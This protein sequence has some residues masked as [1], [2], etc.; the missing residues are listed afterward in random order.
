MKRL[1]LLCLLPLA[2]LFPD[3]HTKLELKR[4]HHTLQTDAGPCHYTAITGTIPLFKLGEKKIA[5]MFFVAYIEKDK[6]DKAITFV[7]PG[8]PGGSCA[9]EVISTI[10][11]RRMQTAEEGG[12]ILPPYKMIDNPESLLPWTDLVFVD[13]VGTGFSRLA[14]DL[15]D[16]AEPM[17]DLLCSVDG[18]IASLGHFTR[19]FISYFKRWNSP[20]YLAGISYGTLRCCGLAEYLRGFDFNIH[21]LILLSSALDYSL[22]LT[23]H[24]QP[25]AECLSIPTYAATAWYHKRFW[26]EKTL[27]EVI[28]Y[29]KRF[30]Y[31]EYAPIMLQPSRLSPSELNA[32]YQRLGDLI[33]LPLETVKRY[34]G[35]FDENLYTT[36]F[37]GNERK[38]IGGFDSRYIGDLAETRRQGYEDPSYADVH[39]TFCTFNAYLQKELD[40]DKPFDLYI[41]GASQAWNFGTYDSIAWP[42]VVQRIR[43]TLIHNPRMLVF[44]GSGYYDCRTPFAATE[45]CFEHLDLP[46]S[47]KKNLQFEYYDAGHGFVFHLPSLQKLKKNLVTF[48]EKK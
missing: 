3:D 37:L 32:F 47:Y 31:E 23:Q 7:F 9:A 25:L 34:S 16:D 41:S 42:D 44:S 46:L 13:P 24:N 36:E 1:F 39:G 45:Y 4:T 14:D 2:A 40:T 8:G 28:E 19:T 17:T 29:A 12:T 18:D 6:T 27:P 48:Y 35:R 38:V 33:G 20:K 10:G 22:L 5:D 43:R 26:P 11:P 21:G 30:I 15:G